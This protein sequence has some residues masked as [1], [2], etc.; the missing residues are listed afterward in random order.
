MAKIIKEIHDLINLAF[1]KG[2]T[3]YIPSGDRD[4][5]I[6]Q[7]QI[8]LQRNLFKEFVLN[9]RVRNDLLPFEML[10][11]IGLPAGVIPADFEQEIEGWSVSDGKEYPLT[12]LESGFY[13]TRKLDV[14]SPPSLEVP[15]ATINFQGAKTL[16]VVPTDITSVQLR[17]WRLPVKPQYVETPN[18]I[19]QMVYDDGASVDVEWSR[20][21]IDILMENTFTVLGLNLKE[22]MLSQAGRPPQPKLATL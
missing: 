13:R 3:D 16:D 19:G 1:D 7:G 8:L 9:K 12:I 4:N 11:T 18:G 10:A 5:A 21:M 17:Y 20:G 15:I 2:Y 14:V 6:D 22:F